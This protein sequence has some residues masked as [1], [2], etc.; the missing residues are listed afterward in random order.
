[1]AVKRF[2]ESNL[3]VIKTGAYENTPEGQLVGLIENGLIKSGKKKLKVYDFSKERSRGFANIF[4]KDVEN[5]V[6]IP[7]SDEGEMSVAISNLNNVADTYPITLV[8]GANFQQKYPSIEVAHYHNLKMQYINPYWVNYQNSA[9]ISYVERF[10][11]EFGTE[12]NSYGFQGFDVS[13][14]FMNALWLYGKDFSGCLPNLKLNLTQGNYKFK[15]VAQAGGYMNEGVSVISYNR[16]FD[17]ERI[18][19]K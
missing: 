10:K 18:E 2:S 17:V 1:M 14:Y 13:Y 9:T 16:G 7:S 8:A 6:I 11:T 15:K 4:M 12:P 5:V 3:V 19:L